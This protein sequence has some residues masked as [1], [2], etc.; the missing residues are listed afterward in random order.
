MEHR[1]LHVWMTEGEFHLVRELAQ[2]RQESVSALIRRLIRVYRLL[3]PP[4]PDLV[5]ASR[6]HGRAREEVGPHVFG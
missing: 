1:Q 2:E 3:Y 4:Q 6:D 5:P